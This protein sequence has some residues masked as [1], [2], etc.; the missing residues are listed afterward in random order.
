MGNFYVNIS[1]KGATQ[2]ELADALRAMMAPAIVGPSFNG[3]CSFVENSIEMQDQE[4]IDQFG[5]AFS[6][7]FGPTVSVLNHDDDMLSVDLYVDGKAVAEF[8][9][10]PGYFN[11]QASEAEL[12]PRWSGVDQ[13]AALGRGISQADVE[14]AFQGDEPFAAEMH[15]RL[16]TLLGLPRYSVGFGFGYASRGEVEGDAADY[17]TVELST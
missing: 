10:C 2:A 9:S 5:A 17:I 3:W 11:E 13:F 7:R 14:A 16:A 4:A 15:E 6:K 1:V 12:A 8:N